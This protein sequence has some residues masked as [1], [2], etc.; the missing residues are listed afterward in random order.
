MVVQKIALGGRRA[1]SPAWEEKERDSFR[2]G[3]GEEDGSAI[4]RLAVNLVRGGK[5]GSKRRTWVSQFDLVKKESQKKERERLLG[6]SNDSITSESAK[7]TAEGGGT[8]RSAVTRPFIARKKSL[9]D[10]Y[11]TQIFEC[12][13]VIKPDAR[14]PSAQGKK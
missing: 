2:T 14:C 4:N 11:N 13:F 6:A 10:I 5:K 9:E 12:V 7:P 8:V 3:G 1:V